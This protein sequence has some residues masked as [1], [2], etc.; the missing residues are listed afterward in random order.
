M[1]QQRAATLLP[2]GGPRPRGPARAPPDDPLRET[3]AVTFRQ[4]AAGPSAGPSA[5]RAPGAAARPARAATSTAPAA[6]RAAPAAPRAAPVAPRPAH[7]S[8]RAALALAL[9]VGS[10]LLACRPAASR[11]PVPAPAPTPTPAASTTASGPGPTA[12]APAS[13][14]PASP[15]ASPSTLPSPAA[16]HY[17][18]TR[19]LADVETRALGEA[20]GLA[21]SQ[22]WPGVYWALN[23]SGNPPELFAIDA[24]GRAR[25]TFRVEGARNIDWEA[26]QL[27]PGADGGFALYIADT[28]DNDRVRREAV[29][30]RVPEPAPAPPGG[31]AVTRRTAPAEAFRISYPDGPRNTEALLVHPRTGEI[32]LATK[33]PSG[34]SALFRVPLPLESRRAAALEPVGRIDLRALVP[35]GGLVTDGAVAPDGR[36]VVVRTYGFALEYAVPDGAPLASI[37]SQAPRLVPLHDGPQAEAITYRADGGA[38]VTTGEGVP[39]HLFE[40][41]WQC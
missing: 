38:L 16:C 23:D 21:A 8:W 30:Y 4:R 36:R 2:T 25:G 11:L 27:G 29:I 28:G 34:Q 37:W 31:P 22:R 18:P 10:I 13:P 39:A 7:A 20:S 15:A 5:T 12:A 32:L 41:P 3:I 14:A 9:L 6:P 19:R 1:E 17:G 26:L 33:E 35:P 24:Q 40:T